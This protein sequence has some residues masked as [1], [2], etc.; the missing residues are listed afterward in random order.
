MATVEAQ[1]QFYENALT[2]VELELLQDSLHD[3]FEHDLLRER[4]PSIALGRG[5][6]PDQRARAKA[7]DCCC[8]DA[9]VPSRSSAERASHTLVQVTRRLNILDQRVRLHP[10]QLSFWVRDQ[11]PIGL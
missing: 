3:R 2:D 5:R 11:E 10:H 6:G 9:N 8:C 4:L 7:R 1:L